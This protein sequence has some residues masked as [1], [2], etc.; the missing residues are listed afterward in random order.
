LPKKVIGRKDKSGVTQVGGTSRAPLDSLTLRLHA[1]P[2]PEFATI[3][4]LW[5]WRLRAALEA[6]LQP[7]QIKCGY[8]ATSPRVSH[9]LSRNSEALF[10][11]FS[12]RHRPE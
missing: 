11:E 8:E 10:A 2:S 6:L 7:G 5:L 9:D 1:T 12:M 3:E 4:V